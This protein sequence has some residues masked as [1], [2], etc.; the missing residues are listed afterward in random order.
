MQSFGPIAILGPGFMGG[1]LALDLKRS[2]Q[3]GEVR[4]WARREN[5]LEAAQAL[6]V[7]DVVSGDF[8]KVV[9]GATLVVLATPL[10]ALSD[11]AHRLLQATQPQPPE[12]VTDIC[13]VKEPVQRVLGP[14]FVKSPVSFIGS[15]PM[16]GSEK[17]GMAASISGLY[18]GATCVLTPSEGERAEALGLLTSFW[19]T[20][21]CQVLK[22]EAAEHD[23]AAARISHLPHIV[24]SALVES[25]LAEAPELARILAASGFRDTT[26]VAMGPAGM[27]AEILTENRAATVE[28]LD[29]LV[30]RL[31]EAR[32]W[33]AG[34]RRAEL[35]SFLEAA[36]GRRAALFSQ[37]S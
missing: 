29:G 12:V 22:S 21:G 2:Q 5:T 32:E 24:A 17:Q 28:A 31:G 8:Q 37:P 13:S 35:E 14:L 36:R 15:H 3:V 4:L 11:L 26:R 18:Q 7:A 20:V 6:Q 30:Q 23:E 19:E 27:W 10:G 9:E 16:C 1:S 34:D 25:S 33:I